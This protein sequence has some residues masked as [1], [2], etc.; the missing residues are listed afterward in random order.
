MIIQAQAH[1]YCEYVELMQGQQLRPPLSLDL[2]MSSFCEFCRSDS[3]DNHKG[4][5]RM[6]VFVFEL[7][8]LIQCFLLKGDVS[9]CTS[10]KSEM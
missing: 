10:I 9:I 6:V 5:V 2:T 3:R 7:K 8:R 1:E 4:K